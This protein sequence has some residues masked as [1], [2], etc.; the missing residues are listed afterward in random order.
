MMKPRFKLGSVNEC[1]LIGIDQPAHAPFDLLGQG[2]QM[3]QAMV[4]G[5]LGQAPFM[6]MGDPTGL[7]QQG[8]H[9]LPDRLFQ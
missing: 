9:V 6:F 4:L 2:F 3:L 8:T 1:V 5:R 7:L